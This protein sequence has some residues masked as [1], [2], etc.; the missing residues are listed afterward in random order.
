MRN[1]QLIL[2]T[3]G[4]KSVVFNELPFY[5]PLHGVSP[6]C[7]CKGRYITCT[8]SCPIINIL[9]LQRD[10]C[11]YFHLVSLA[12]ITGLS[13]AFLHS[14]AAS[15]LCLCVC[16]CLMPTLSTLLVFGHCLIADRGEIMSHFLFLPLLEK[17]H[18]KVVCTF[19]LQH[20]PHFTISFHN[21]RW[22][23]VFTALYFY[24][25]NLNIPSNFFIVYCQ[26]CYMVV[27][28]GHLY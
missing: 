25:F 14:S 5:M 2:R 8:S 21:Y 9:T 11:H 10:A 16:V 6:T 3:Q 22:L 23:E 1:K 7:I 18:S 17:L 26:L 20:V 13:V 19:F 27:R 12:V 4:P 15:I 28:H 24:K